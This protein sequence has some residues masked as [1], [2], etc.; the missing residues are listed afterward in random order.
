MFQFVHNACIAGDK[1]D[2]HTDFSVFFF[3]EWNVAYVS[4]V[5]S[6]TGVNNGLGSLRL[7]P[8]ALQSQDP[9]ED[10]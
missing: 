2:C 6:E 10:N 4:V 3:F 8:P 9:Q 5:F 7:P 1:K